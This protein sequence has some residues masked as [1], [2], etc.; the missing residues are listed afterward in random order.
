[1]KLVL[2]RPLNKEHLFIKDR[3]KFPNG[4]RLREAPLYSNC[5]TVVNPVGWSIAQLFSTQIGT[6]YDVHEL[7]YFYFLGNQ[8]FLPAPLAVDVKMLANKAK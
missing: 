6:P 7:L 4:V 2:Y 8:H 5:K 1:M 3:N